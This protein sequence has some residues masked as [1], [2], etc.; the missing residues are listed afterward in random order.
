MDGRENAQIKFGEINCYSRIDGPKRI[1]VG[2][3]FSCDYCLTTVLSSYESQKISRRRMGVVDRCPLAR[4][5]HETTFRNERAR[6]FFL[7][8]VAKTSSGV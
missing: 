4:F 2:I 8:C 6:V 3:E 5:I 1:F 7:I